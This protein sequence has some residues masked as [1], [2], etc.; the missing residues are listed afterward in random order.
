MKKTIRNL[1][2]SGLLAATM[3]LAPKPTDASPIGVMNECWARRQTAFNQCV[4]STYQGLDWCN[5]MY[6]HWA[7]F[8]IASFNLCAQP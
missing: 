4:G 1:T 6:T 3:F 2:L 5:I 8:C 7:N